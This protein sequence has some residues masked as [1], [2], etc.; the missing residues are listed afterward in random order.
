[1]IECTCNQDFLYLLKASHGVT[2]YVVLK[3]CQQMAICMKLHNNEVNKN[4]KY[5]IKKG[6]LKR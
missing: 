3:S 4:D 5:M 1:M 2:K 6:L